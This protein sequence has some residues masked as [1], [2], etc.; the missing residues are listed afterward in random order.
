[1]SSVDFLDACANGSLSHS[2]CVTQ[3]QL[4][5]AGVQSK[6]LQKAIGGGHL[7]VV[8]SLLKVSPPIPMTSDVARV[9]SYGSL[10]MYR[11]V[12]SAHPYI[13][14]WDFEFIGNAIIIAISN[15]NLE[16]L[17]YILSHGGDPG[18]SPNA[19]ASRW[20][21][22]FSP[23]DV[24]AM[25]KDLE[26]ARLLI[27]HGATLERTDAL[28]I[29]VLSQDVEQA[30]FFIDQGVDVDFVRQEDDDWWRSGCNGGALHKAVEE[31]LL[32]MVRLLVENGADPMVQ[33]YD[34][35]SAMEMAHDFGNMDILETLRKGRPNATRSIR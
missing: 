6:G 9:S 32:D 23:L 27:S 1:M 35:R 3:T 13:L 17:D 29:S 34:G 8:R 33:A 7:D 24:S 22:V 30:R 15:K 28:I 31:G 2:Q 4:Q 12:H 21:Y 14:N 16:L 20:A 5:D 18:R 10:A 26:A 11:L 19:P 25:M